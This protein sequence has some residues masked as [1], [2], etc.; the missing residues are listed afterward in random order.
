MGKELIAFFCLSSWYLVTVI[1]LWRFVS[2]P[3]V[4]MPQVIMVF[5]DHTHLFSM[6]RLRDTRVVHL[7]FPC[8]MTVGLFTGNPFVPDTDNHQII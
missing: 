3:W 6:G 5:L 8:V 4:G 1:V 2:M 7:S